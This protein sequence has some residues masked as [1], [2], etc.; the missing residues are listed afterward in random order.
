MTLVKKLKFTQY[1]KELGMRIR[2]KLTNL[3]QY[4]YIDLTAMATLH[5]IGL[6]G[7]VK[8]KVEKV[9]FTLEQAAKAQRRSRAIVLLFL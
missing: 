7:K 2:I 1:K 6:G 5:I 3:P 8:V 9:M 4:L